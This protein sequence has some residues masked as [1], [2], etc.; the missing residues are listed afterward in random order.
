MRAMRIAFSFA[1]AP[2]L[3]KKKVSMSPGV[4]SA[5]FAASRARTS[6]AINGFA[7]DNVSACFW[8]ARTTRSSLCPMFTHIN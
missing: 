7:Y 5:S 3:V 8:I 6:V 4:I 2:P 1:S